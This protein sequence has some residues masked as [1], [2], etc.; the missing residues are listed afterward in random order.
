MGAL[1]LSFALAETQRAE[2]SQFHAPQFFFIFQRTF[3]YSSVLFGASSHNT[4]HEEMR[5]RVPLICSLDPF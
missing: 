3:A 2:M 1:L 4:F 5:E